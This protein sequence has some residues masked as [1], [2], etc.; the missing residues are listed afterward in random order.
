MA[1]P[2]DHALGG[3]IRWVRLRDQPF[4]DWHVVDRPAVRN[5]DVVMMTLCGE[6]LGRT[7]DVERAGFGIV[8]GN[9]CLSCQGVLLNEP[10]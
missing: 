1:G 8:A 3:P 10:G 5:D 6:V 2:S 9:R 4:T 7:E